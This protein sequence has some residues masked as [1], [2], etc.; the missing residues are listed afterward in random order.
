MIS[1][2]CPPRVGIQYKRTRF[3]IFYFLFL[4]YFFWFCLRV[5]PARTPLR[6]HALDAAEAQFNT[7]FYGHAWDAAQCGGLQSY[8]AYMARR[9]RLQA[10]MASDRRGP[11][12]CLRRVE[13]DPPPKSV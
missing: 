5:E 12:N 7:E 10:Y 13:V 4:F 6:F 3:F 2:T 11:P 9:P 1:A 8:K